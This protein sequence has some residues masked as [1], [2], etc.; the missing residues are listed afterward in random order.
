MRK[1]RAS[2]LYR[3]RLGAAAE[4]SRPSS[5]PSFCKSLVQS[6][7]RL[8]RKDKTPGMMSREAGAIGD[9]T[10]VGF[11]NNEDRKSARCRSSVS[12]FRKRYFGARKHK[13]G[14]QTQM[15]GVLCQLMSLQVRGEWRVCPACRLTPAAAFCPPKAAAV[16]IH[17][18]QPGQAQCLWRVPR[19]RSWLAAVARGER[20][21]R[22]SW[23]S[24]PAVATTV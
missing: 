12:R 10:D 2:R 14:P 17:E 15:L 11:P 24:P 3:L 19:R 9:K 23:L 18:G 4:P 22:P 5:P 21:R 7:S 13:N 16:P 6:R 8:A 20:R 1:L